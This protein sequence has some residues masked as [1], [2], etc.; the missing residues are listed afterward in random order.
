[1]TTMPDVLPTFAFNGVDEAVW[2]LDSPSE[3][4][5]IQV[6]LR[7]SGRLTECRLRTALGEALARHHPMARARQLPAA[8]WDRH[9]YWQI[10]PQPD[11]DAL[12][13][14][15]CPDDDALALARRELYS[16]RIPL[17]E[18]PPLRMRLAHHPAGDLV[19]LNVNHAAFDG[20]GALRLLRSTARAYAGL[21]D[22]L[23]DIELATARQIGPQLATADLRTRAQRWTGVVNKLADLARPPARIAP[24]HG[25]DQPG[26]GFHHLSLSQQ[27]TTALASHTH[28]GTINDVLVAALNLAIARWNHDHATTTDRISIIVPVNFR[29][30]QWRHDMAVNY[31]LI[32]WIHTTATDRHTPQTTLQAVTA[33]TQ[34]IKN[35]GTGTT[36]IEVLAVSPR[37]PLWA[38][39][40]LSPL[41]RLTGNRLV[42]T[43]QLS[44]LGRLDQP[45]YF[46]PDAGPTTQAW[47]SPPARMP[48]GLSIGV[49]TLTGRMHLAFRY[50]HPLLGPDAINRFAQH[51]LAELADLVPDFTP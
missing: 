10:T 48:C 28:Q 20:F 15:E 46:G 11:L 2:L 16:L 19:M 43:A 41:L 22:P 49:V 34:R 51:Y 21:D 8:P 47:F 13:V 45:P 3:P 44:N 18:S 25:S 17:A 9:Y 38:Q 50:R 36:L 42:D 24:E 12:R 39:Q 31:V 29:P 35:T 40:S 6:E 32:T 27:Q 5:N 14:V 30:P 37:L 26:Y 1:M 7:V 33:Q 23:P 4:W